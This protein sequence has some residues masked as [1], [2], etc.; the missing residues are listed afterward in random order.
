MVAVCTIMHPLRRSCWPPDRLL[1]GL[2]CDAFAQL[3]SAGLLA[4]LE[5]LSGL[6]KCQIYKE[7]CMLNIQSLAHATLLPAIATV[8]N[9][10]LLVSLLRGAGGD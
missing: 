8:P 9:E 10:W 2:A 7:V 6:I 4:R 1:W 3:A 5:F